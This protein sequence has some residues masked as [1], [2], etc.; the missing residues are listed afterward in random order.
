MASTPR[1][2]TLQPTPEDVRIARLATAAIVLSVAEAAIPLPLPGVKPGLG[3]IVV[4][5][6]ALSYG[7]RAA[8]WVSGLRVLATSLVL[9][10]FLAPGFFFS[11]GG[12]LASLT[13]L[14]MTLRLP[15]RWFGPVTHSVLGSFAHL[16]AQL[17][18]ARCWLV[19]H[20]GVFYLL[21]VFAGSALLFGLVNGLVVGH[22]RPR[23]PVFS[24]SVMR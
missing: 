17:W 1:T 23:F 2:L 21:P 3:N 5:L 19:P 24:S 14:A 15:P 12:A 4:V 9:G 7:W 20:D 13:M 11:L 22:L 10:T 16:G 8:V 18:I 6:V